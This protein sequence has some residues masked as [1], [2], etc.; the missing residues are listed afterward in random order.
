MSQ[1]IQNCCEAPASTAV[2]TK[3]TTPHYKVTRSEGTYNV[4]IAMPGVNK[5]GVE[6][7]VDKDILTVSGTR[8]NRAPESWKRISRESVEN[9]YR[10]RLRLADDIDAGKAEAKVAD[11]ILTLTLPQAEAARPRTIAVQ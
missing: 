5:Q 10:L 2:E 1:T 4:S 8:V 9:D 11:G 7:S 3:A 6:L